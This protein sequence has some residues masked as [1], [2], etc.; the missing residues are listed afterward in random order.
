M[1]IIL[2]KIYERWYKFLISVGYMKKFHFIFYAPKLE[3][4]YAQ[5]C[6]TS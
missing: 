3:S 2:N 5:G 1:K 6:F 4:D